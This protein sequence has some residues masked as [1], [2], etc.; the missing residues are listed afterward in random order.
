MNSD[1]S[2]HLYD[3]KKHYLSTKQYK[4][5]AENRKKTEADTRSQAVL[6]KS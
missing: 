6:G 3:N 2:E 5:L 4:D 1:G